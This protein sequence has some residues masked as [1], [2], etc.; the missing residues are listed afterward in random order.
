MGILLATED[1]GE[2][3]ARARRGFENEREESENFRV[4]PQASDPFVVQMQVMNSLACPV[5]VSIGTLGNRIIKLY[6]DLYQKFFFNR[7]WQDKK[8]VVNELV[9]AGT[10]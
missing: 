3:L 10:L 8:P 7:I 6:V 9:E 5:L 1:V 2:S 4:K